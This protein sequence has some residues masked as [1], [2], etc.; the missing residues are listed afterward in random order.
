MAPRELLLPNAFSLNLFERGNTS[1][2]NSQI[3]WRFSYFDGVVPAALALLTF[4][5]RNVDR[6][7]TINRLNQLDVRHNKNVS[8]IIFVLPQQFQSFARSVQ[9]YFRLERAADLF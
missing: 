3:L 7:I 2:T 5:S 9:C 1:L 4:G 6:N 8:Q